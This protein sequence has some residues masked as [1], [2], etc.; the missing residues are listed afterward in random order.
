M[1][2]I[3][4]FDNTLLFQ[5]SN[6]WIQT[7]TGK[8]FHPLDPRAE[9]IDIIDIARAL[10]R[11]CRF[12]GHL[13]CDIAY[14]VAQHS[15]LVSDNC[16]EKDKLFGLLHDSAEAFSADL[17][18]PLKRSGAF[19]NFKYYENQLQ[20]VIYKKYCG[21][22]KEPAEVKEADLRM[23]STEA[24]QLMAPLHKDWVLG[25]KSYLIKIEPL[26]PNEAEKLFMQRFN[27]LYKGAR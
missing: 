22:D 6:A 8:K 7:Y 24:E 12:N 9:E 19:D 2:Y 4:P 15:I 25:L 16:S 14:S 10:S 11:I 13:K 5:T 21:S 26:Q 20:S 3:D 17:A 23:L 1:K 27:E 18:S